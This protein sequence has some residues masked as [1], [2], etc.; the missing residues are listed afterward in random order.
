[1]AFS[2][3]FENRLGDKLNGSRPCDMISDNDNQSPENQTHGPKDFVS[4]NI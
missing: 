4:V 1:M 3:F 2:S